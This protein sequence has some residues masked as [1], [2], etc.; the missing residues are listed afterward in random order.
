MAAHHGDRP[1]DVAGQAVIIADFSYSL[2][3][4]R[5][6]AAAA[7][8]LVVLDHHKTAE[9]SLVGRPEFEARFDLEKSGAVIAW[10]YAFPDQPVPDLLRYIQDG[11][12]WR[13]E[14]PGAREISAAL[15]SYPY[16]FRVWQGLAVDR[17]REEGVAILRYQNQQIARLRD[18]AGLE[19]FAGYRVPVLNTSVWQSELG[20]ELAQGR[21]FAVLWYE[22]AGERVYSLRS[23]YQ[24]VDVGQLAGSLGGGGH[25][26]AAGF[27]IPK[28]APPTITPTPPDRPG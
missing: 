8:S 4:L 10:E 14:L 26:N 18:R 2:P 19:D 23:T 12:L 11:D 24:G 7:R 28:P 6:L 16:D 1:P 3:V 20:N 15:G 22:T 25:R 27:R 21:P 5:E 9:P 13:W 17:L